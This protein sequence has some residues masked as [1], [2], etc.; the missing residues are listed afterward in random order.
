LRVE[1]GLKGTRR[2]GMGRIGRAGLCAL[3]SSASQNT[4]CQTFVIFRTREGSRDDVDLEDSHLLLSRRT[5]SCGRSTAT[6]VRFVQG[7]IHHHRFTHMHRSLVM[8]MPAISHWRQGWPPQLLFKKSGISCRHLS[9]CVLPNR[10]LR[11]SL[12]LLFASSTDG[13]RQ[14]VHRDKSREER[15]NGRS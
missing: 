2:S 1:G 4:T 7:C 15:V 5:K 10:E 6:A 12:Q 11:Y 8:P 9:P 14:E 13:V 3:A